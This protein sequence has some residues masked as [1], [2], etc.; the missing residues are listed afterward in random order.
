VLWHPYVTH[1]VRRE[2]ARYGTHG[3]VV[4]IPTIPG[5]DYPITFFVTTRGNEMSGRRG[6]RVRKHANWGR[7][8]ASREVFFLFFFSIRY[9]RIFKEG[10]NDNGNGSGNGMI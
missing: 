9:S 8:E 6:V 5:N 1:A 4:V 3:L 7:R 2:Y 10:G